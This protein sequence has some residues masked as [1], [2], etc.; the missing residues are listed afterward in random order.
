MQKLVPPLSG[1]NFFLKH[2]HILRNLVYSICD[3]EIHTFPPPPPPH[4]M[5]LSLRGLI[6]RL[7]IVCTLLCG[8][9]S[10][11]A[12]VVFEPH[13]GFSTA[14]SYFAATNCRAH[15]SAHVTPGD[16]H[17]SEAWMEIN[18]ERV[19]T[20]EPIPMPPPKLQ[21]RYSVNPF[22]IWD[23]THFPN[24]STGVV[25]L[26]VVSLPSG[27]VSAHDYSAPIINS[28]MLYNFN[29]SP[30]YKG[31]VIPDAA[32]IVKQAFSIPNINCSRYYR[33]MSPNTWTKPQFLADLNNSTI[34]FFA[35]HGSEGDHDDD[36]VIPQSGSDSGI[37]PTDYL[38]SRIPQMGNG[39][40][41]YNSGSAFT[42]LVWILSCG[43]GEYSNFITGCY[44][45]LNAYGNWNENQ[46]F[47]GFGPSIAVKDFTFYA[48]ELSAAL[49]EGWTVASARNIM[50]E[51]AIYINELEV[52][53][54]HD[55]QGNYI[56]VPYVPFSLKVWV[57][58]GTTVSSVYTG[59]PLY[60][61]T[62]WYLVI[63]S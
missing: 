7:I 57:D 15:Y 63:G 52:S 24:G 59:E 56:W 39:L 28:A 33:G 1:L 22:L 34:A 3:E 54:D 13:P 38:N 44:P 8:T 62:S 10:A 48:T 2:H 20:A 4:K 30:D 41:P 16:L 51:K 19:W 6:C 31:T 14:P 55:A 60:K 40:H 12:G 58:W 61:S 29:G 36:D 49:V 21:K 45:Y 18:G 32:V 47:L 25:K 53:E 43:S 26:F 50:E 46:S 17:I 42:S 37:T 23:S 35:G 11:Y 9:F 27:D 5:R